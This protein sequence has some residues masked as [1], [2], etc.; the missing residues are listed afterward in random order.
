MSQSLLTYF[1]GIAVKRISDVEVKPKKSNQHE[2]NG[3]KAFKELLGIDKR[4]FKTKFLYLTDDDIRNI[5]EDS[6]VTWYDSREK[7]EKRTEHRLYYKSLALIDSVNAGD[8]MIFCEIDKKSALIIFAAQGSNIEKQLLWLFGLEEVTGSFIVKDFSKTEIEVGYA[9]AYILEAIGIEIKYKES[10]YL[11]QILKRFGKTFP[12]TKDFSSFARSTVKG[13]TPLDDPDFVLIKW[14]EQEEILFK[15]L[16][17]YLLEEKL[18]IGFGKSGK[19][20]EEFIKF[21]LSIHQRRKSRAGWAFDHHV[22][23]I[24]DAY[25]IKYS[26]QAKTEGKSKPDF[27]FPGTKQYNLRS[28]PEELLTMLGIKTTAKDRWRQVLAEADKI[29][30]KHLLTLEPAISVDQTNE[31]KNKLVQLVVPTEVLNSYNKKQKEEIINFSEFI[32]IV[33]LKQEKN[34]RMA[35]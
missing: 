5:S 16:E 21:S 30:T 19:D 15:I 2:F 6:S 35:I 17:K 14:M 29:K 7:N 3:S 13:L 32:K 9:R 18:K 27:L 26:R 20:V 10:N 11:D 25:K 24:F 33:K 1:K 31:M 22:A 4:V 34:D 28:Y 12:S 8:M 23:E